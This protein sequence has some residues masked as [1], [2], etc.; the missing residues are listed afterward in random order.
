MV[1]PAL[2]A[3]GLVTGCQ[4]LQDSPPQEAPG[5]TAGFTTDFRASDTE[6]K[7]LGFSSR[8]RDIERSVGIR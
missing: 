3:A 2:I 8:A 4:S 1:V 7:P 5:E 6:T